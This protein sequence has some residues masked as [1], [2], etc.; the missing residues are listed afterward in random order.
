M[1]DFNF[2]PK[3]Y[4]E[5]L[6]KR[7]S[8][9]VIKKVVIPYS[10]VMVLMIVAPIGINFKLKRDKK[11]IQSEVSNEAYYRDK[12]DQYNILKSIYKQR[13]EQVKNLENYGIDP[14]NVIEDL[15]EVM[16]DNVY[17]QYL[18]MNEIQKG[19]FTIS[20]RC[21]AKTRE[22]AATFVEVLRKDERYYYAT[23]TSFD[24]SKENG[25]VEFNFSC[26]YSEK[27]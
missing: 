12:N 21:V 9:R 18:N 13:E 2:L 20:M 14:T 17:I 26:T 7:K 16:P 24:E 5:D 25:T 4:R 3:G 27:V 1:K 8:S 19:T 22:D 11:T 6:R 15:Q 23:L 10:V